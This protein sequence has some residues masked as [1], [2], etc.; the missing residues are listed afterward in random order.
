[1]IGGLRKLI[2]EHDSEAALWN[3]LPSD[4]KISRLFLNFH[5]ICF[6]TRIHSEKK[7]QKGGAG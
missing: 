7:S 4:I 5:E 2:K 1:M 3:Y 6:C